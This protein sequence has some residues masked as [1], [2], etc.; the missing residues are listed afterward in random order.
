M[1]LVTSDFFL[2]PYKMSQS[3]KIINI[4]FSLKINS[5]FVKPYFW[6]IKNECLILQKI[7]NKI[8]KL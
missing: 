8:E 3:N 6:H 5:Y 4:I 7:H 2:S 1:V